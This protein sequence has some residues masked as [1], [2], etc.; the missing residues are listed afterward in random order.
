MA[1]SA[2]ARV[3]DLKF[4]IGKF[5]LGEASIQWEKVHG[6]M[7]L[8]PTDAAPTGKHE[9]ID[10]G[11]PVLSVGLQQQTRIDNDAL[12][13]KHPEI[14]IECSK[15]IKFFRFDQPRGKKR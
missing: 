8:R 10:G 15:Q 5:M 3:E 9:L 4:E 12:R 11:W 2:E 1:R 13:S 7:K 6:Q 14:A